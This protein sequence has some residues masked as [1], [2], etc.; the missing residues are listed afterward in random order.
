MIESVVVFALVGALAAG[1][2][3]AGIGDLLFG[4]RARGA[5]DV[6]L[7]CAFWGAAI[8]LAAVLPFGPS[9]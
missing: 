1:S 7:G 6:A 8:W 2:W 9:R 3:I 5:F 4:R